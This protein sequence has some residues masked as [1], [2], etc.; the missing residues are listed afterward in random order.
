MTKAEVFNELL[1]RYEK[2]KTNLIWEFS[3]NI[4]QSEE[5]LKKE[6]SA[7]E[8]RYEEAECNE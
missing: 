7:W 1:R 2:E 3:C 8:K 4:E 6:V 5:M